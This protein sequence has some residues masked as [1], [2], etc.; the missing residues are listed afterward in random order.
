MS[1]MQRPF[2]ASVNDHAAGRSDSRRRNQSRTR[3]SK[4]S[5]FVKRLLLSRLRG[6]RLRRA[7]YEWQFQYDRNHPHRSACTD[8]AGADCHRDAGRHL[9]DDSRHV[10]G[11]VRT[12][13]ETTGSPLLIPRDAISDVSERFVA[14]A[15]KKT[16][17]LAH[18]EK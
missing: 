11:E 6:R 12:A 5:N 15:A 1:F 17:G 7:T 10:V 8:L 9:F 13:D 16:A 14:Q 3:G 2:A 4:P 18:G